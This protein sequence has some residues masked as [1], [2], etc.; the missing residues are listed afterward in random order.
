MATDCGSNVRKAV[1]EM[2][3]NGHIKCIN[4][5]INTCLQDAIKACCKNY[6]TIRRGFRYAKGL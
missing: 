4:H 2:M 5:R 6:T 1:V 3:K